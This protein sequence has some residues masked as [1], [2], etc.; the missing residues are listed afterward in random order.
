[1]SAK[2]TRRDFE[3]I[4]AE[5][6]KRILHGT[7]RRG[8][9][10]PSMPELVEEFKKALATIQSAIGVLKGEGY[11]RSEPGRGVFVETR[12]PLIVTAAAYIKP[13]PGKF[14]YDIIDVAEVVPPPIVAEA[15]GI[16]FDD[17]VVLRHRMMRFAG[18]PV[19]LSWSYYPITLARG[20]A[21]ARKARIPGGVPRVLTESGYPE[22]RL[23]DRMR[24]RAPI[25]SEVE[26]LDLPKGISVLE[27]FRVV[28]SDDPRPVEVS[29]LVKGG[30]RYELEHSAVIEE[31]P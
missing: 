13:E 23:V 3:R 5:L 14:T 26:Q 16:G 15:F 25:T 10:I 22:K 28:Y 17:L 27:Q 1:V 9:Q 21:L 4:A 11:L 12:P 29:I 31:A 6:R 19:E 7:Y 30:H 24:I 18:E 20:T 8:E 2:D